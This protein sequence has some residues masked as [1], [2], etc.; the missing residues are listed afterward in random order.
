[1]VMQWLLGTFYRLRHSNEPL[2]RTGGCYGH[3]TVYNRLVTRCYG[4]AVVAR[5]ILPSAKVIDLTG[6]AIAQ[7]GKR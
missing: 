7:P 4:H 2:L 3:M 1:M 6:F 5:Y